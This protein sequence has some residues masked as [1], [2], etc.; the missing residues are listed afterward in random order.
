VLR[1]TGERINYPGATKSVFT[2]ELAFE[3]H[4]TSIPTYRAMDRQGV[5]AAAHDPKLPEDTL[6]KMYKGMVTLNVMDNI[7]Y[8]AQ[9]QGRIS[10]YMTNYGEEATHFGS[11]AALV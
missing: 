2:E 8:D 6:V 10:F 5:L 11:S 3:K 7:L 1:S 9:R 4:A